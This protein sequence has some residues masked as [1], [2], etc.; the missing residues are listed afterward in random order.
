MF[1]TGINLLFK[2]L[3]SGD[4]LAADTVVAD[5]Y[6]AL[7]EKE[8]PEILYGNMTKVDASGKVITSWVSTT[9]YHVVRNLKNGTYTITE[10][11]P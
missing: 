10:T 1:C 9:N 11:T 8:Y 4:C 3:N 7:N 6:S 2:I 5:M